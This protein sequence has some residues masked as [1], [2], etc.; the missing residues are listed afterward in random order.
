MRETDKTLRRFTCIVEFIIKFDNA[1]TE[2]EYIMF[3]RLVSSI[4]CIA[5]FTGCM[6]TNKVSA[7]AV[8]S[9]ESS[10]KEKVR[11]AYGGAKLSSLKTVRIRSERG[12]AWPGQG[13]TADFVEFASDRFEIKLDL[14]ANEGS[15]ERY[16]NQNGN[17]Y[18]GRETTVPEGIAIIN[19][20]TN[21][22]FIEK[23]DVF[24]DY[25]DWV[26]R[27]TDLLLAYSFVNDPH[28]VL[29]LTPQMYQGIV[30]ER[31]SFKTLPDAPSGTIYIDQKTGLIARY[32]MQRPY[33]TA[34]TLFSAY[35]H[36]D[37]IPYASQTMSFRNDKLVRYELNVD[38]EVNL[39][40]ASTFSIESTL[41]PQPEQVDTS[42]M[43]VDEIAEKVFH[44]GQLGAYSTFVDA[45]DYIIG[46]NAY[47]GLSERFA[48]FQDIQESKK[49]LKFMILSHHHSDHLVGVPDAIA[50][51]A[52]IVSTPMTLKVLQSD[53]TLDSGKFLRLGLKT[54]LGPINIH[55]IET[56]HVVEMAIGYMPDQKVL[57]QDDHFAGDNKDSVSRINQSDLV[58][59]DN[60]KALGLE[61]NWLLSGHSRKAETWSAFKAAAAETFLGDI[62]PN[63]R[64]ICQQE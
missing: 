37:D 30:Y 59:Q 4:V 54:T 63:D 38:V 39:V 58:L 29:V 3:F 64:R 7:T 26:F 40:K 46:F 15:V 53:K 20:F 11:M 22:Y 27:S 60:V 12:L 8:S 55:V 35:K 44:V 36:D 1:Y 18:S 45:G 50:L 42:K 61:I 5:I 62:C 10:I 32:F 14:K 6:T 33:G 47:E 41:S 28:D 17:V 25:F 24:T 2:Q 51:G 9:T 34:N 52:T 31:V 13:Q 43:S 56:N 49:P 16:T 23:D 21:T 19:Y 48:A 57:Y